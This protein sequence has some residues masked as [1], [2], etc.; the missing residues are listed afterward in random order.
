MFTLRM[1]IVL[2]TWHV[3]LQRKVEN[4]IELPSDRFR[5]GFFLL[6]VEE[7]NRRLSFKSRKLFHMNI[8][9]RI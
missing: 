1:K 8:L 7:N 2:R 9:Y 4:Y 3:Y 5:L 6:I